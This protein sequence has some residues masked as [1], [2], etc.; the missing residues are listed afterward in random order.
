LPRLSPFF[1]H[2]YL[3]IFGAMAL[4]VLPLRAPLFIAAMLFRHYFHAFADT[5]TLIFI[6]DF[7]QMLSRAD[8]SRCCR[9]YF[10]Y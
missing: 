10:H 6:F 4:L 2:D 9:H 7:R 5:P 8:A 3:P 1:S